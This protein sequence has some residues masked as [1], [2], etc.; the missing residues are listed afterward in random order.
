MLRRGLRGQAWAKVSDWEIRRKQ[1]SYTVDTIKAWVRRYP[2]AA[3]FWI[4]GSDQWMALAFW[5]EPQELRRSLHFLVFPRPEKPR[6]RRGFWMREIPLRLDVSATDIRMRLR[7]KLPIQGLVLPG[8]E[9]M[10]LRK[11]WYR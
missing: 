11:R 5:K 6:V 8:V 7:K 3:F 10:I 2:R 9:Q 4:M 1:I